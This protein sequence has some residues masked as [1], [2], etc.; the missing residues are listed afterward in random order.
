MKL[1]EAVGLVTPRRRPRGQRD[2]PRRLTRCH[3]I[4]DLH[5]AAARRLPHV[6]FDYLEGGA[7]DEATLAANTGSWRAHRW[8]PRSLTDVSEVE[9]TVQL[10]GTEWTLPFGLAPTGYSLLAHPGGESAAARAA[11]L[12]G[13]PYAVSNVAT[14]SVTNVLDA[15]R[16]VAP[17]A[18]VWTQ[19]YLCRDREVSWRYLDLA[20]QAGSQV[21]LVSV[22]TAVAGNRVRDLHNGLT[23]PPRVSWGNLADIARR[24]SY[25]SGV[26]S[27]PSFAFA[28][29]SSTDGAMTIASMT[30]L[31]DPSLSWPDLAE[32]RSHWPGTVLLKGPIGPEE[33]R[34]AVDHGVDGIYLSNHGGRQLDRCVTPAELLPAVR[35][36][37]GPDAPL[38][39]DSGIRTGA[40]VLT[41]VALGADAAMLG[42]AYLYGLAVAGQAG[43]THVVGLVAAEVRRTLQL[44]GA[45]SVGQLRAE[46]DRFLLNGRV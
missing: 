14:T 21:L 2:L 29:L 22:D 35:T 45:T 10:C 9:T 37:L 23:I 27:G 17:A 44:V 13:I 12:A 42:R 19:L 1:G 41:A 26:L 6:V 28:N 7:D 11:A 40:D 20:Q 31:F 32:I 39:C 4:A 3:T 18:E 33:A 43:V 8:R 36:A 15:A 30:D 46:A 5:V 24:P 25:W 38:L 34:R 16:A